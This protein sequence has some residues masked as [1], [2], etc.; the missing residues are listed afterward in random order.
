MKLTNNEIYTRA[1]ELAHFNELD[2]YIPVK[3]NFKIQKNIAALTAAA[4]EI[5]KARAKIAEYF[6]NKEDEHFIIPEDKREEAYAELDNLSNM[7][8]DLDIEMFNLADLGEIQLKPSAMQ[9]I[10]FMIEG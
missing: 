2:I 9:S 10:M 1:L 6:G 7:E 5:E 3:A 8:Q 4:Q